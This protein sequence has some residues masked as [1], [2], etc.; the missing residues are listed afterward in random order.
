M[1]TWDEAKRLRNLRVHGL[2]FVG[3]EAIWNEFAVTREDAR[4]DYGEIRYVTFG[5]LRG[6]IVALIHTERDGDIRYISLRRADTYEAY[7]Y[8]EA[9]IGRG[10]RGH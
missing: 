8:F 2:D 10:F 9:A 7:A 6:E 5:Y 3:A 1:P 4:E